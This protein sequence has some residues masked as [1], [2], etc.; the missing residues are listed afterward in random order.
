MLEIFIVCVDSIPVE[1]D[2]INNLV[3]QLFI[4]FLKKLKPPNVPK[5]EPP[6][7]QNKEATL[8]GISLFYDICIE[9]HLITD[10][11]NLYQLFLRFFIRVLNPHYTKNLRKVT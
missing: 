10:R 1:I 4:F 3:F 9:I 7:P 5:S 6:H 8:I 2:S 11:I